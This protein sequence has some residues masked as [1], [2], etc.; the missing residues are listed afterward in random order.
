MRRWCLVSPRQLAPFFVLVALITAAAVATRFDLVA[1]KL[2]AGAA[3]AIMLAVLPLIFLAGYFEGRLDY[4]DTLTDFPLWMRIR[5]WPVKAAFAFGFMYLVCLAAQTW[6]I[7]IGPVNPNPPAS[8]P[9]ATRA[10][11]F[12]MF[13]GGFFLI[14]YMA[15]ASALIP[16]LRVLTAPLRRLPDLAGGLVALLVGGGLGVV[17]MSALSSVKLGVFIRGIKASIDASPGLSVGVTL[18][19]T[20]GPL[21]IG[22][23]LDRGDD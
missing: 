7:S 9:A 3:T 8:F 2:P 10:M 11:W 13:T 6:N 12:A 19:M 20:L 22:A 15:A 23:I 21:V 5:S 4:G 1:A 14:F 17:V 16:V 18:G